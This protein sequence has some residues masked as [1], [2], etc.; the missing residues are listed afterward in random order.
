MTLHRELRGNIAYLAF[1]RP[2][3]HNALRDEDLQ[4]LIDALAWLDHTDEAKLAI[5]F[6][7][8]PS[9]SSGADIAQR[10]EASVEEQSTAARVNETDA[11]L[12]CEH[13][14]PIVAAVH[15][16]CLGHAL[17]T[18]LQCDLIVA[19]SDTRFQVTEIRIGLPVG[20]IAAHF[21]NRAFGDEVSMTGR[22]FSAHEAFSA[23]M[24]GRV[25]APGSHI[26]EAE[27]IAASI[28]ENP[29]PAVRE[30]VRVRRTLAAERSARSNALSAKFAAGWASRIE[31]SQA[32]AARAAM[33]RR[34]R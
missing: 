25:V 6:G 19:T 20:S 1:N 27:S 5:L 10:L 29:Q 26:E 16:Y 32:I 30:H 4:D 17:H 34:A 3:K 24:I 22:M 21:A 7:R 33:H 23:G 31:T 15:G 12:S 9:F 13:W 28:L 2:E 18:A 11:F 8:G 14:K